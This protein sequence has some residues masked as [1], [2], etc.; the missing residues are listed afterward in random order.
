MSLQA[1]RRKRDFG[2]TSE[3][4]ANTHT[5]NAHRFVVQKHAASRLHYD[6]RLQ[7][8]SSLKSWA[9]PK[10]IPYQH[11]Q[12][13]LAVQV[14]DHPVTYADFEGQIPKDQYGGGTVLLWDRGTFVSLTSSPAKDLK[15][16][17]LHFVLNGEK[18]KGE[19]YLVRLRTDDQWLLIRAGE[20]MKPVSQRQDDTSV[21]SGKT[22]YQLARKV[23]NAAKVGRKPLIGFIE[24]MK[25]KLSTSPPSGDWLYEIKFDGWRAIAIIANSETRLISRN[26]KDIG[27]KFPLLLE[28][29]L[30]LRAED[31][32]VDGEIVALD[33]KGRSSFQ[34][35]QAHELKEE[36]PPIFFYAF[37]LLHCDGESLLT[38]PLEER[39]ARLEKLLPDSDGPLRFSDTLGSEAKP[40]LA[41]ASKLKLEGLIGKRRRSRYE[42][43]RRSG[44]WIKLKLSREQEFVI[45]G[46][47]E[48]NGARSCFGS[49]LLGYYLKGDLRF[50]GK[51]G[52]GFNQKALTAIH[53]T[54][55]DISRVTCPFADLP[56]TKIGRW[57]QGIGAAE[58]KHCS[59]VKPM[60]VCQVKYAEWTTEG[61]LRHPVFIALRNDKA[62]REVVRESE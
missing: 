15:R 37:D 21:L 62:A 49:L 18:L 29:L 47:T 24:P 34:L 8:G 13:R 40:L 14:E 38:V 7:V 27:S 12:K 53:Q 58:L 60:L 28:A 43:G 11:G 32:I 10:G 52:T 16:G 1:Y 19:W 50:A 31:A 33:T 17:K 41:Q 45:G 59:W 26:N 54:M 4:A 42:P 48:P 39:K 35:L 22:M 2:K 57:G 51:V 61:K 44:A 36:R 9:V 25:A 23:D 46:Y 20:D 3:P 5:N 6:L 30:K 56:E 55:Q